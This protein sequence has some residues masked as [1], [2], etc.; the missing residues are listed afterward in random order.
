MKIKIQNFDIKHRKWLN[1]G[2]KIVIWTFKKPNIEQ[3]L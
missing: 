1:F 2:L 3:C